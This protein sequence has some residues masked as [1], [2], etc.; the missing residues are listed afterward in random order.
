MPT[1]GYQHDPDLFE[2]PYNF[3]PDRFDP[4]N[5]INRD[6]LLYFGT[7]P[8]ACIGERFARLQTKVALA[9]LLKNFKFEVSEEL[10][11]KKVQFNTKTLLLTSRDG[12]LLTMENI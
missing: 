6:A 8:R 7:G 3:D 5:S 9:L 11:N 4:K 2:N 1:Y 12:L 10:K